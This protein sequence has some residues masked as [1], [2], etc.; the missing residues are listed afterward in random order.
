ATEPLL[1]PSATETCDGFGGDGEVEDYSWTFSPTVA[2]VRGFVATRN[3][4]GGLLAALALLIVL[5]IGGGKKS[6]QVGSPRKS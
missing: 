1:A 4:S 6:R 5:V 2:T 3:V